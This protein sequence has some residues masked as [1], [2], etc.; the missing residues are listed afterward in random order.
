[1]STALLQLN[2]GE[3]MWL[4]NTYQLNNR[5]IP[6]KAFLFEYTHILDKNEAVA[7]DYE[8]WF[9]VFILD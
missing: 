8:K 9:S 4:I 2:T 7:H 1:M 5:E 3:V 6:S